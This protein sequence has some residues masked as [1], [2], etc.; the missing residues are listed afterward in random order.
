MLR[1]RVENRIANRGR[2]SL[3]LVRQKRFELLESERVAIC[4]LR[5]DDA[6]R[7]INDRV[8][9]LQIDFRRL[10][11]ELTANAKRQRRRFDRDRRRFAFAEQVRIEMAGIR[12]ADLAALE[13]EDRECER[14]ERAALRRSIDELIESLKE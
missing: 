14:H 9:F 12:V 13:I 2:R 11:G 1:D 7:Q 10:R 4:V 6:V 3:R 8:A 5:F